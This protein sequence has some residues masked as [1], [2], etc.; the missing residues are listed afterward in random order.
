MSKMMYQETQKLQ[1]WLQRKLTADE[2]IEPVSSEHQASAV[3]IP[4]QLGI[5]AVRVSKM[6]NDDVERYAVT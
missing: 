2:E 6:N 1:I 5:G 4:V 3:V